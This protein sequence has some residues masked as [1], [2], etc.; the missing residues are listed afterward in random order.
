M[1]V[2]ILENRRKA[3][4][5]TASRVKIQFH[6]L[7][8]RSFMAH[9]LKG[10]D[11]QFYWTLNSYLSKRL[12][13]L[14]DQMRWADLEWDE[15]LFEL[16][17]QLPLAGYQYVSKIKQVLDP[18]HGELREKGFLEDVRYDEDDRVYYRVLEAF[19]RRRAA[20]EL[21]GNPA[22]FI[23]IER[24]LSEGVRGDVARDLVAKHGAKR[25]L[26]C[27]DALPFQSGIRNP[28]GW[29][30]RAI[31][32]GFELPN[33]SLRQRH[34]ARPV[35]SSAEHE[36]ARTLIGPDHVISHE[37]E[38]AAEGR[39]P[40]PVELPAPDPEA[41]QVWANLV[42][43][44]V[45]LRG[46]KALPPWFEQFEGGQ[47]EGSTLTVVVPNSYAANH[48]NENFGEDLVHLW[49]ERSGEEGAVVQVAMDLSSGVRAQLCVNA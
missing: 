47:L 14:I 37:D 15:D 4:G 13:R 12:Y 31:E 35:L 32:E 11:T 39:Q 7:F 10:L 43:D 21:S 33:T 5:R 45:A 24:L 22:E 3:D 40:E 34:S 20:F 48:L 42:E 8:I 38:E 28:A 2:K 25:C 26:R 1:K 44:L 6:D 36:E 23:A 49:R 16:Q 19:A 9:Y 18:A 17:K 46:S 29:L 27:A 41:Q 30:R